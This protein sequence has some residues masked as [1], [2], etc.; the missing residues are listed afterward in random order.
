MYNSGFRK[1][2]DLMVVQN[3]VNSDTESWLDV[4]VTEQELDDGMDD[5]NLEICE[6]MFFLPEGW[7]C[8]LHPDC[9]NVDCYYLNPK[10]S[11]YVRGSRNCIIAFLKMKKFEAKK[12]LEK[13][14]I[15]AVK[16]G[17]CKR[18]PCFTIAR[19]KAITELGLEIEHDLHINKEIRYHMY[20]WVSRELHGFL[21][22]GK[23]KILP[24]CVYSMVREMY[25]SS[26]GYT[27]FISNLNV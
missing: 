25:P 20:R 7:M 6:P 24:M 22:K 17:M 9:P 11:I 19:K 5:H 18:T 13:K 8:K 4:T 23:R 16:C 26:D 2:D 15:A 10:Y 1:V 3:A 12:G 14:T 21:G 27:G